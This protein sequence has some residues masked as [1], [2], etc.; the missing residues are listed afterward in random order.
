MIIKLLISKIIKNKFKSFLIMMTLFVWVLFTLFLLFFYNNIENFF[1]KKWIWEVSFKKFDIYPKSAAWTFNMSNSWYDNNTLQKF[2]NLKLDPNIEKVY[3]FYNTDLPV[4]IKINL[5]NNT[6]DTDI[7]L[8]I[9]SDNFFVDHHLADMSWDVLNFWVSQS[10][11]DFYNLQ[12]ANWE[13]FPTVPQE[14]FYTIKFDVYFGKSVFLNFAVNDLVKKW[15]IA[16]IDNVLPV[17]WLTMP[18]TSAMSVLNSIDRWK[19]RLN[20]VSW[21][22]KDESYIKT[23][24]QQFSWFQVSSDQKAI[25]KIKD[26]L[27]GLRIFLI[28]LNIAVVILLFNFVVYIV[29]TLIESNSKIFQVFR[30]HWSSKFTILKIILFEVLIYTIVALLFVMLTYFCIRFLFLESINIWLNKTYKFNY[31]L[32]SLSL[33]NLFVV[34]VLYIVFIVFVS[35]FTSYKHWNKNFENLKK[36]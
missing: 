5:F 30:V 31:N 28:F 25:S 32:I 4:S 1:I 15:R 18:Y 6:I 34:F 20:R 24:E 11:I 36:Y 7:F 8:F 10:L 13:F 14:L 3:Y 19:V 16:V 33:N 17:L 29:Y 27:I 26:K 2:E 22:V 9:V 21:Y 12:L 35:V 23:I